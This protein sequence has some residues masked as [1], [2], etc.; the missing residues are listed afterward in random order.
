[1]ASESKCRQ[2]HGAIV[3]RNGN[4]LSIATNKN[5]NPMNVLDEEHVRE[6]ASI[7]AEVAALRRVAN[8]RGC[9]VYV[10]RVMSDGSPGLSKPCI[11]CQKYLDK[12]GVKQVVWT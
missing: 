3:V 9:T 12:A 5:I 2:R 8:P 7:H 10:A 1:M 6:H 11:R 4:V